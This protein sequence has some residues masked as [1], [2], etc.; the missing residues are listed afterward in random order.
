MGRISFIDLQISHA[1]GYTADRMNTP[2]KRIFVHLKGAFAWPGI[3]TAFMQID[4]HKF[5]PVFLGFVLL[6]LLTSCT[7]FHGN[8]NERSSSI[9]EYLYPKQDRP[10]VS[11]QMPV[12]E[13]PLRVGIAFAPQD[14]PWHNNFSGMEQEKLLEQVA[15]TF[16]SQPFVANIEVIPS[17][18]LRP[19]G[20][21]ENLDQ[22]KRLLGLDVVVLVSY[23][24]M[25]FTGDNMLSLAYWTIVGAYVFK[26]SKNDTQTLIEAAVYDI[27]SRSL[28]FRAP[29]T[30][31]LK[32]SSTAIKTAEQRHND[33]SASLALAVQ[34]MTRNLDANLATFKERIKQGTAKVQIRSQPGYTGGGA[35]D[36]FY[37]LLLLACGGLAWLWRKS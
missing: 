32:S 11:E 4:M 3:K 12:L 17:S 19:K 15:Q 33:A 35:L 14:N 30:N 24:Q 36:G 9:V 13:L 28:L 26:G 8:R 2:F 37:A 27:P 5:S 29:G 10:L 23:D 21:F 31:Q 6:A 20:G 7:G 25:Q 18:Y 34:D 1:L 22:V 16:R